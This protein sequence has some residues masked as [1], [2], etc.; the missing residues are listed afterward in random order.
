MELDNSDVRAHPRAVTSLPSTS[1]MLGRTSNNQTG[2]VVNFPD[3]CAPAF[4]SCY[5]AI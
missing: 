1:T 5:G 4:L 2:C 3:P